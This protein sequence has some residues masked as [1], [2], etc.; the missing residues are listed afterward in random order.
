MKYV[1]CGKSHVFRDSPEFE[2]S[3]YFQMMSNLEA[4]SAS[5]ATY[6]FAITNALSEE[7]KRRIGKECE[8]GFLPN[9][10]HA[11]RFVPKKPNFELKSTLEIPREAVVL[12]YIGSV[13][14]YE[15]LD[16]LI[17]SL[18]LVKERTAKIVQVDDRWGWRL[19]AKVA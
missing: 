14:S 11:N 13:V 2:G 8:V 5:E 7:M 4:N 16:L 15:G 18:P 3:E 1:A 17:E 10:V 12:G 6:V 19:Y 9:G